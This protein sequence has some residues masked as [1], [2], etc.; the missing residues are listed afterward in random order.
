ME[1]AGWFVIAANVVLAAVNGYYALAHKRAE[2]DHD[3]A[4]KALDAEKLTLQQQVDALAA[5]LV[6]MEA[7]DVACQKRAADLA[8]QL[9]RKQAEHRAEVA[10]LRERIDELTDRLTATGG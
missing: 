7:A 6:Q 5:R 8:A 3:R 2:L 9:D 4:V 1:T 10:E